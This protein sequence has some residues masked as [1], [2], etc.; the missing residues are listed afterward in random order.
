[1]CCDW[2]GLEKVVVSMF[3]GAFQLYTMIPFYAI[4]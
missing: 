4:M 3:T 2:K 1:M